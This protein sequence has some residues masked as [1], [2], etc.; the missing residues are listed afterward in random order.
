MKTGDRLRDRPED[1]FPRNEDEDD[2]WEAL[3]FDLEGELLG[4][5]LLRFDDPAGEPFR[6]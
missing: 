5:L 1:V 2:L 3:R 4:E 6:I